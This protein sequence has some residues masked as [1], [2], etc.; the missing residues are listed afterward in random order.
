YKQSIKIVNEANQSEIFRQDFDLNIEIPRG[1]KQAEVGTVAQLN[2]INF[3]SYGK[4][5]AQVI[6]DEKLIDESE[7]EISKRS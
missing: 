5:M 2:N 1:K 7:I 3:A 6:V 4:Y